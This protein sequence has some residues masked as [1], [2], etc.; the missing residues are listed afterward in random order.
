MIIF[1]HCRFKPLAIPFEQAVKQTTTTEKLEQAGTKSAAWL[2]SRFSPNMMQLFRTNSR[3][4]QIVWRDSTAQEWLRGADGLTPVQCLDVIG[5]RSNV[6]MEHKR[7]LPIG[8][9]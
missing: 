9:P 2:E 4:R 5:C 7:P 6:L 1:W 8:C 3:P